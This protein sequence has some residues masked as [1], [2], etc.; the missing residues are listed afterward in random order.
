MT[1]KIEKE[2]LDAANLHVIDKYTLGQSCYYAETSKLLTEKI[3][4]SKALNT[5]IE[6]TSSPNVLRIAIDAIASPFWNQGSDPI[7]VIITLSRNYI[8]SSIH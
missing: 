8:V 3:L 7:N 5:A 2:D 4:E 1:K 6:R